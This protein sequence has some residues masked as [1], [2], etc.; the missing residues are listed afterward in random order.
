MNRTSSLRAYS[1]QYHK[2]STQQKQSQWCGVDHKSK[3]MFSECSQLFFTFDEIIGETT[4][5]CTIILPIN[6]KDYWKIECH[7]Q[8]VWTIIFSMDT[9]LMNIVFNDRRSWGDIHAGEKTKKIKNEKPLLEMQKSRYKISRSTSWSGRR[10]FALLAWEDVWLRMGKALEIFRIIWTKSGLLDQWT[11]I[12]ISYSSKTLQ[13][14][15]KGATSKWLDV[16]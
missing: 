12:R 13:W 3:P 15:S 2:L 11:P 6:E 9:I 1:T 10:R 4:L 8:D 16:F 7:H 5:K 14:P